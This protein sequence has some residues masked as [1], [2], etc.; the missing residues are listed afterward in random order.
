MKNLCCLL[1]K[2]FVKILLFFLETKTKQQAI[3]IVKPQRIMMKIKK[4]K[5]Y[6][7]FNIFTL[8]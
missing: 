2:L 5:L 6:P 4:K 3:K 7:I 1:A 8:I